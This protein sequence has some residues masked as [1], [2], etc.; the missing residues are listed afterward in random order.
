[1]DTNTVVNSSNAASSFLRVNFIFD[2]E[3]LYNKT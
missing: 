2:R 3:I 1:M